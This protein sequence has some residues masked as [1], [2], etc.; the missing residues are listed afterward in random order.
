MHYKNVAKQKSMFCRSHHYLVNTDECAE[1]YRC[2]PDIYL[3]S[4]LAHI[5]NIIIDCGVGVPIHRR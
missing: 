2:E 5:Y 3:L 4:M 1:E